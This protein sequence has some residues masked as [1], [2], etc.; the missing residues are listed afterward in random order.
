MLRRNESDR[1]KE[2]SFQKV[3]TVASS[4]INELSTIFTYPELTVFRYMYIDSV[5]ADFSVQPGEKKLF[6]FEF[7]RNGI[8]T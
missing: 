3:S 7:K 2:F 6:F 1:K 4:F 8:R 5:L